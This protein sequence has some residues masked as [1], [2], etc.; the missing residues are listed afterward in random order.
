VGPRR[1]SES[2]I[3]ATGGV[4]ALQLNH[5]ISPDRKMIRV[6]ATIFALYGAYVVSA[7]YVQPHWFTIALGAA[8]LAAGVG[9]WLRKRWSQYLVYVVSFVVAGQWLWAAISYY[10]STAW[11]SEKTFVHIL[12]LIP[13]LSIVALA[14]GSS[15]L[16]FRC[17]RVR[18]GD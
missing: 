15:I 5:G 12:G 4:R 8:S 10:S 7:V 9:L 13:G 1:S 11:P 2:T 17:F 6:V 14:I 18:R 3:F 16:A